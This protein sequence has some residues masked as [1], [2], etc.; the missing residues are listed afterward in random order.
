MS[1]APR[2]QSEGWSHTGGL[3]TS[4]DCD[5]YMFP[6]R[7]LVC[8][9]QWVGLPLVVVLPLGQLISFFPSLPGSVLGSGDMVH[10]LLSCGV[11]HASC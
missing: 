8:W 5:N 3:L 4:V 10:G 6:G 9:A 2:C 1:E 7:L 11:P